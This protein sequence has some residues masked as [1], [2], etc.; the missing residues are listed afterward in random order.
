MF[1]HVAYKVGLQMSNSVFTDSESE[2]QTLLGKALHYSDE[3]LNKDMAH[4]A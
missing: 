2:V 3:C 4:T 1:T